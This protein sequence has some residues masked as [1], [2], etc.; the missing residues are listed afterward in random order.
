[1]R[2][3][4][5]GASLMLLAVG[6]SPA[7]ADT[8]SVVD[9]VAQINTACSTSYDVL[10]NRGGAVDGPVDLVVS[11]GRLAVGSQGAGLVLDSATGT[12]GALS[13]SGLSDRKR[14]RA[15]RY[16]KRSDTTHW[17][18]RGVFPDQQS[19]WTASYEQARDA[20]VDIGSD[21]A[22]A[23]AGQ[24]FTRDGDT[25]RFAT[26][27]VSVDGA[28]RLGAW[29][30]Q[31]IERRFTYAVRSID[32]PERT[33]SFARWARASQAAS[34]N[35]TLRTLGR[36]IATTVSESPATVTA[37]AEQAT[38]V[39]AAPRAVPVKV[40]ALRKGTLLYARNPYTKRYHAWRVYVR[41]E[42]AVA[43]RVAP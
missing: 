43:R 17:L 20:L 27:T 4:V 37:I 34:L 29:E 42:R 7:T 1:M 12:Y 18:N 19:G 23:L 2:T 32:L 28:G 14:A 11:P 36:Q 24:S 31:G 10:V 3:A 33:V 35:A 8:G 41:G 22:D 25:W 38:A 39:A 21:C 40:R 6:M 5:A 30:E 13:D 9:A 16:L 26:A 15:L